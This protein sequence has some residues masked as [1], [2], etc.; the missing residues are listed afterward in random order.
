MFYLE[1]DSIEP[2]HADTFH[3][4]FVIRHPSLTPTKMSPPCTLPLP[5]PCARKT[6]VLVESTSRLGQEHDAA[7][8]RV[9]QLIREG[10]AVLNR[11]QGSGSSCVTADSTGLKKRAS[12]G[13]GYKQRSGTSSSGSGSSS[14]SDGNS[15]NTRR[16]GCG[17]GSQRP[18]DKATPKEDN[19]DDSDS[20]ESGSEQEAKIMRSRGPVTLTE[21]FALP[22]LRACVTM[23]I[24]SKGGKRGNARAGRG[25]EKAVSISR[26]TA[27]S[28][29][30]KGFKGKVVGRGARGKGSS[31]GCAEAAVGSREVT[32]EKLLA[33][34]RYWTEKRN[35]YGGPMLRCF[36]EFMMKL[37][38]RMEDPVR[39]VR[40][41]R[42]EEGRGCCTVWFDGD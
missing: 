38:R 16:R 42:G 2:S 37:W 6:V 13:S 36:H 22:L 25:G 30:A 17:A 3:P 23:A 9:S 26:K 21:M 29:K 35:K 27:T 40:K 1:V 28:K 11:K 14:D 10:D 24:S 32:D 5:P 15:S 39:E 33:V 12:H 4:L 19:D 20:D 41:W 34:F 31:S 18:K 7:T 8:E